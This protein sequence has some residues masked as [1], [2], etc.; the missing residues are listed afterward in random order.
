MMSS[1]RRDVGGL[2]PAEA[3]DE[4]ER[5]AD[6][7]ADANTNA[8]A[9][10]NDAMTTNAEVIIYIATSLDGYIARSDGSIDWLGFGIGTEEAERGTSDFRELLGGVDCLVMGRKTFETVRDF[11]PWPYGKLPIVVLSSTMMTDPPPEIEG[12]G[13]IRVRSPAESPADLVRDLVGEGLRKIYVDG[14][15]TIR[16]FLRHDLVD[17]M[18]ISTVPMLLGAGV[19]LFSGGGAPEVRL[20]LESSVAYASGIV[21]S[22][23]RRERGRA[24]EAHA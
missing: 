20:I 24:G 22:T 4:Y 2:R 13:L 8:N 21:K 5:D 14:G 19:P 9:N 23:Y 15:E 10:A 1:E 11:D 18:T 16:G 7:D 6:A 3:R 12:A 17:A